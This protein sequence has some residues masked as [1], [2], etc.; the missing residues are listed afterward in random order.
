MLEIVIPGGK[1][2]HNII[3]KRSFDWA[4][5]ISLFNPDGTVYDLTDCVL[6]LKAYEKPGYDTPALEMASDDLVPQIVVDADP[7]TGLFTLGLT[8][9]ETEAYEVAEARY[10]LTL[11]DADAS[12]WKVLAGIVASTPTYY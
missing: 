10:A 5:E 2:P 1:E 9:A 11:T 8:A 4:E 6:N 3:L 7:T 12:V